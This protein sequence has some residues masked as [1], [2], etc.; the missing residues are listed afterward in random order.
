MKISKPTDF[1]KVQDAIAKLNAQIGFGSGGSQYTPD[2]SLAVKSINKGKAMLRNQKTPILPHN[3][4]SRSL[5]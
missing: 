2:V 4:K 3:P 5:V 1:R